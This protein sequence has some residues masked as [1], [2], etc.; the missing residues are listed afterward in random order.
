MLKSD[1]RSFTIRNTASHCTGL[2]HD[3]FDFWGAAGTRRVAPSSPRRVTGALLRVKE[4]SIDR[5]HR[6]EPDPRSCA[7]VTASFKPGITGRLCDCA[8]SWTNSAVVQ[9]FQFSVLTSARNRDK[10]V[11]T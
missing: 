3:H 4:L 10:P 1:W 5:V 2:V 7:P 8:R 6:G 9:Q 11:H